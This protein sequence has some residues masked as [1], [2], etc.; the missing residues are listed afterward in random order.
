MCSSMPTGSG[1]DDVHDF[2]HP[3][4]NARRP[5]LPLTVL[6]PLRRLSSENMNVQRQNEGVSY[7]THFLPWLQMNCLPLNAMALTMPLC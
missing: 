7:R 1:Q 6:P 3:R 2:I 5:A 4:M